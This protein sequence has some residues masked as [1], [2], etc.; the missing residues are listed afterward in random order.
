MTDDELRSIVDPDLM[1]LREVFKRFCNINL[2]D[3][4]LRGF[5]DGRDSAYD[6]FLE[7]DKI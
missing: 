6:E 1:A 3:E 7:D 5:E 4:Y 2:S